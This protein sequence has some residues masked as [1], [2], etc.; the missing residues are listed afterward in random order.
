MRDVISEAESAKVTRSMYAETRREKAEI[1][2]AI[3]TS[4]WNLEMDPL[5]VTPELAVSLKHDF[6]NG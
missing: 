1:I 3:V 4:E 5:T 6:A 2:Q